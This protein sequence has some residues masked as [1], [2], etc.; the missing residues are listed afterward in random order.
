LILIV[1]E[2]K[3]DISTISF[4]MMLCIDINSWFFF[5]L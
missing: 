5:S 4:I 2:K 1:D 3:N